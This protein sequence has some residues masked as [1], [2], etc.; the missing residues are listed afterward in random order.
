MIEL[1]RFAG[2]MLATGTVIALVIAWLED[3]EEKMTAIM[4]WAL[5]LAWALGVFAL[6][7]Y[8]GANGL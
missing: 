5:V 3:D 1:A 6:W 2:S 8:Y 7:A 4:A